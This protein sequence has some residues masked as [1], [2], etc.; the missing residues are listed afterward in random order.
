MFQQPLLQ[1]LIVNKSNNISDDN[2][3]DNEADNEDLHNNVVLKGLKLPRSKEE[4][5]SANTHFKNNMAIQNDINDIDETAQQFQSSIYECFLENFGKHENSNEDGFSVKYASYPKNRLKK[6][7][8]TLKNDEKS[9]ISGVTYVSRLLRS[10]LSKGEKSYQPNLDHS[11]KIR[12]NF[13]SY[14][15]EILESEPAV[16]PSFD[17]STCFSYFKDSLACKNKTHNF[18]LPSWIVSMEPP[19]VEFDLSPIQYVEI[20]KSVKHMKS[21]ASPCPFDHISILVFK[22]CPIL[23]TYL[24]RIINKCWLDRSISGVWKNGFTILIYKKGETSDPSN[25]RPIILEPVC[26]K[27]LSSIIRR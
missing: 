25:F 17:Q 14:C 11:Y 12:K 23:R 20:A 26:M 10:K 7:L 4:W 16:Q 18:E 6:V 27:I 5:D 8:K 22:N 24:H 3:S 1:E 21:S 19:S 15:K 13:W 9:D 2:N